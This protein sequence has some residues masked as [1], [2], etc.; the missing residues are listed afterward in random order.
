MAKTTTEKCIVNPNTH[1]HG[2]C[3]I[4]ATDDGFVQLVSEH[5]GIKRVIEFT[6][7][8][9]DAVAVGGIKLGVVAQSAV[10]SRKVQVPAFELSPKLAEA[11]RKAN[12]GRKK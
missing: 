4:F 2:T 12:N 11:V 1:E 6:T 8:E 9:W 3:G 5:D 7:E 10:Q